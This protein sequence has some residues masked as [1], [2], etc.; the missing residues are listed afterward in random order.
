[1]GF[2][3]PRFF[4]GPSVEVYW[5]AWVWSFRTHSH[6]I[7][8]YLDEISSFCTAGDGGGKVTLLFGR[9]SIGSRFPIG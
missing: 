5:L 4:R 7:L 3:G 6:K 9:V 8:S 2:E 1:M